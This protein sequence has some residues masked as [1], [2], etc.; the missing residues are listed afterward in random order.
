VSSKLG[1]ILWLGG[2]LVLMLTLAGCP[3]QAPASPRLCATPSDAQDTSCL[4]RGA[5]VGAWYDLRMFDASTGWASTYNAL[6]RTSDGGQHWKAVTP[7]QTASPWGH[8]ANF[9]TANVAWVLQ[10]SNPDKHLPVQIFSTQ[11]GGRTWQSASLPDTMATATSGATYITAS[12]VFAADGQTAWAAVRATYSPPTNPDDIQVSFVHFWRTRDGGQQWTLALDTLP[13]QTPQQIPP[14]GELWVSFPTLQ[15][16]FMSEVQ[17]QSILATTDAGQTWHRQQLPPIDQTAT[18]PGTVL[19]GAPT[20]ITPSD[21]ILPV[22]AFHRNGDGQSVNVYY[23]THDGGADWQPTPPLVLSG[24]QPTN[25][26]TATHWA[27]V[28]ENGILYQTQDAGQTWI[29]TKVSSSFLRLT[30]VRFL[31][32]TEVWGIGDNDT[33]R[34]S[35]KGAESDLTVPVRSVDGGLTW[36]PVTP[37]IVS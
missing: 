17:A 18:E 26:I 7:W 22:T 11:D 28:A 12:G 16:G 24:T 1:R 37:Y 35:F 8:T 3:W 33:H 34:G 14:G 21:G 6:L 5:S 30:S 13:Q 10:Q 31:S 23:V 29:Q 2:S 25:F 19:L 32:P 36:S 27:V 15:H 20:F 9:V 4:N